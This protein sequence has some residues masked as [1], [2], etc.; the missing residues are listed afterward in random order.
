M[1]KIS[2]N[3]PIKQLI[4]KH[5]KI[6]DIMYSLGFVHI[7]NPTMLNTVGKIITIKKGVEKHKLDMEMVKQTF[8]NE[9]FILEDSN[10]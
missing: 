8:L 6:K 3:V 5:P 1:E 2:I 7:V 10:E 9:G 4:E